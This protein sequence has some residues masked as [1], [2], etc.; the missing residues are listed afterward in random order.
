[1]G[2]NINTVLRQLHAAAEH[3]QSVMDEH[4]VNLNLRHVEVDEMWTFVGKKQ[5]RLTVEEKA[6]CFDKGDVYLWYGVDQ[7]TKLIPALLCGKRNADNARRF[8]R[9]L[10]SHVVFPKPHSSDAHH[11]ASGGYKPVIQISTDGF[12]AYPEA[13]GMF[14]GPYAR[15]GTIV[16]EYRNNKLPYHPSEVVG[17]KRRPVFNL[18]G[19]ERSI[20]TSHIER[21]NLTVRTFMKRSRG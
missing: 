11:F 8:M 6:R 1:M 3:C 12:A 7:D 14:F 4:F 10:A 15:F 19:R 20:R 18:Q 16:K 21:C 9:S 13:V 17:T 5:A 2:T